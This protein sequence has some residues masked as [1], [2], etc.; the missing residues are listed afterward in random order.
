MRNLNFVSIKIRSFFGVKILKKKQINFF[1]KC[2]FK[3]FLTTFLQNVS[4][5]RISE[6]WFFL[7]YSVQQVGFLSP[8]TRC[9]FYVSNADQ[10]N[11]LVFLDFFNFD[12]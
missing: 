6:F 12:V 11:V 10:R 4:L 9:L 5:F 2:S 7:F 8:M 3:Y 1:H